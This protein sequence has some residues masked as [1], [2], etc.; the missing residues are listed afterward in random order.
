MDKKDITFFKIIASIICGILVIGSLMYLTKDYKTHDQ[1][2]K[3]QSDELRKDMDSVNK[4]IENGD[5]KQF[6]NKK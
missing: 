5:T 3:E 2:L 6:E 4:A 1:Q